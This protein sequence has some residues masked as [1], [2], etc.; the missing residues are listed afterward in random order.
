[1]RALKFTWKKSKIYVNTRHAFGNFGGDSLGALQH[2]LPKD[3]VT[4]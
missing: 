2:G 3:L 1:M 4:A